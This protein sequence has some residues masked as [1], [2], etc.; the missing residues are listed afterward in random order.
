MD[1]LTDVE[2]ASFLAALK[3]ISAESSRRVFYVKRT[4]WR[5]MIAANNVGL[6]IAATRKRRA[7]LR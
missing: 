2:M 6:R 1:P 7:R 4:T 5:R 3:R